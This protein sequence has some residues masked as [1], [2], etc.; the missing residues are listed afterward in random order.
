[1]LKPVA[2]NESPAIE[3]CEF[4][5][6]LRNLQRIHTLAPH[7]RARL[8]SSVVTEGTD[9]LRESQVSERLC[10]FPSVSLSS[11]PDSRRPRSRQK[12]RGREKQCRNLA[13]TT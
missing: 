12:R 5:G 3:A 8:K 9:V 2:G 6:S 10:H 4:K 7:T 1:M 13:N 11:C